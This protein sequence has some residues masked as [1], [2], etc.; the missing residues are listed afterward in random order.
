MK[1]FW[2]SVYKAETERTGGKIL[3]V[4][5]KAMTV[6]KVVEK[7]ETTDLQDIKQQVGVIGYNQEECHNGKCKTEGGRRGFIPKEKEVFQNSPKKVFQGS[8][9]KGK[10][11]S[12]PGQ[13]PIKCYRCDG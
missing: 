5:A 8:P 4:K 3:N 13:K 10:G 2:P 1:S 9:Q 7:K 6:K 12:K 11:I